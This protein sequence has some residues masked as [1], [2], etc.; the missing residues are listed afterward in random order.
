MDVVYASIGTANQVTSGS[1]WMPVAAAAAS[2]YTITG[3]NTTASRLAE[4]MS[5]SSSSY[6]LIKRA[7]GVVSLPAVKRLSLEVS[8]MLKGAAVAQRISIAGVPC[9]VISR[10]PYPRKF[11]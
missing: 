3:P 9:F 6:D 11:I 10:D 5:K 8:K 7:W 1:M 2:Y 4:V